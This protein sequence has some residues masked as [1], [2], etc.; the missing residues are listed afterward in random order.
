MVLALHRTSADPA[1]TLRNARANPAAPRRR[2]KVLAVAADVDGMIIEQV[3]VRAHPASAVATDPDARAEEA[4]RASEQRFRIATQSL[5]DVVYEWDLED[6]VEWYGDVDGLMGYPRGGFPRTLAA[7]RA[8]LHPEDQQR[9]LAALEAVVQSAAPYDVEYRVQRKDGGW[10]WWRA[11]GAVVRDE[12]GVP[13][14]MIG[15]VSDV[16]DR[17]RAEEALRA[18]EER[19]DA[20][21]RRSLNLV[22]VTDLE[23]RFIDANDAALDRLGYSKDEIHSL[24]FASLLSADQLPLAFETLAETLKTGVQRGVTEYRLRH[25]DGRD[26]HVETQGAIVLSNGAPVAFQAVARDITARRHAEAALRASEARFRAVFDNATDGLVLTDLTTGKFAMANRALCQMLGYAEDELVGLGLEDIHPAATLRELAEGFAAMTRGVSSGS[27][28]LPV[29]RKDGTVFLADVRGARVI[30]DGA[31]FAIGSFRDMTELHRLQ[32]SLA[33]SDR[34]ASMGMLA[35]GV[36]HEINN[37]LAYVLNNVESLALDLPKLAGAALRCGAAVREHGGDAALTALAG[38]GAELLQPDMLQDAVDRAREALEGARRIKAITRGLGT[39]S[40]VERVECAPVD[41]NAAIDHAATMAHN[42]I[43]YRARL[44]KDLGPVPA[45]WASEGKVAQVFLNLLV[46]AAQAIDEGNAEHHRITVRTWSDG[47]EVLAEVSDTGKGIPPENVERVFEP[48]FS[49][50]MVS[51]GSGLGLAIC[52]NI[53]TGFGGDIRVESQVGQGTRFVVR[54]PVPLA[55]PQAPPDQ[56]APATPATPTVRGRL[57]VVDDEAA[58]RRTMQRL[59]GRAHEVVTAASG[60]EAR[61]ILERDHAFDLV[62]CDLMMPEMSGMDLHAWLAQHDPALA[63]RVVFVTGGAFTPRASEYVA[64]VG[65]L[66]I[67]KPFDAANLAR[68]VAE[69]VVAAKSNA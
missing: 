13:R 2:L 10:R 62:L 14:R 11:R 6:W 25:K 61:A 66:R 48:F 50:K 24:N 55:A 59:L 49:T 29:V 23:G 64:R 52:R 36:A 3:R 37:P 47:H 69:L 15:A 65:N 5:S 20:L 31:P 46:N 32:A 8:T 7:W 56:A 68:L 30:L 41:L 38:D 45:V 44:V 17:K 51:A 60:E 63:A 39:F 21:F 27:H 54:L 33:Q 53:V 4:L 67:E 12:R 1:A 35:A 19:Y 57:L 9:V 34:L 40:R 16:T 43:K 58:I 22:F 28:D 18:S 26:V 42:E